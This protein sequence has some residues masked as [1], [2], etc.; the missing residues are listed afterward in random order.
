MAVMVE[1]NHEG[2]QRTMQFKGCTLHR[3]PASGG[4]AKPMTTAPANFPSALLPAGVFKLRQASFS[5]FR[6]AYLP[7]GP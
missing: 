5:S 7:K 2:L 6:A 4:V 3:R 1:I